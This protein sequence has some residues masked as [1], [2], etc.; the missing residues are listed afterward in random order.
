MKKLMIT[1]ALAGMAMFYTAQE[2]VSEVVVPTKE[3][4]VVPNSFGSNWFVSANLGASLY[5]G[6][7]MTLTKESENIFNHAA[8]ALDLYFGKWHTPGFG[9]RAGY[10]GLKMKSFDKAKNNKDWESV[11]YMHYHFDAMFN[12]CNLIG[13]YKADRVWNVIPYAGLGWAARGMSEKNGDSVNSFGKGNSWSGS[14]AV[15]AGILQNFRL[16]SRWA[17]NVEIG[18]TILR[19]GFSAKPGMVGHDAMWR[20]TAGLTYNIGRVGWDNA[21]DVEALQGIYEGMIDDLQNE[22]DDA[23]AA[24]EEKQA[25]IK[26]L[27]NEKAALESEMSQ[28]SKVKPINVHESI[29]FNLGSAKIGSK[30]EELNIKAYA[31]AASAVGTKLAVVGY[32]DI[33]GSTEY[34]IKLSQQRAEAVAEILRANGAEVAV[35]TGNGETE[36]YKDRFLNRRV[37]IKVYEE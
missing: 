34:N 5:H 36:E 18:A 26:D 1:L 6:T 7:T 9:W 4:A 16:S 24:N 17:F 31:E 22:L 10:S 11:A 27:E 33:S 2:T 37:I 14:L 23:L 25:Q 30:K 12:L 21:P 19:N 20:A 28:M 13:G 29:F 15:N 8:F 35:V 32:A 3:H